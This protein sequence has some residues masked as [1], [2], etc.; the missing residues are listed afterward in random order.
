MNH[1]CRTTREPWMAKTR[2]PTTKNTLSTPAQLRS[3]SSRA[4][5]A[6]QTC[7]VY[8][9]RPDD[10]VVVAAN[11]T[12]QDA[13]PHDAI[14]RQISELWPQAQ[15]MLV[16][17]L[18]RVKNSGLP[19]ALSLPDQS[20]TT[21]PCTC[22]PVRDEAGAISA[23]ICTMIG[24]VPPNPPREIEAEQVRRAAMLDR[25]VDNLPVGVLWIDAELNVLYANRLQRE[26]EGIREGDRLPIGPGEHHPHWRD[27]VTRAPVRWEDLPFIRTI[28]TGQGVEM[29]ASIISG[30]DTEVEQLV[31]THPFHD[32]QGNVTEVVVI[33]VDVTEMQRLDQ[34]KEDF[35]NE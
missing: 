29:I 23:L 24:D 19:A 9:V 35:F 5:P 22:V 15:D 33:C 10:Y 3:A 8:T 18:S 25:L 13:L 30:G 11:A 12:T 21:I 32:V 2:K 1:F 6:L 4:S 7:A 20:G 27:A 26:R 17:L 34:M 14:G 16:A 28:R 31:T